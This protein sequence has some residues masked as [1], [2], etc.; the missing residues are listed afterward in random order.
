MHSKNTNIIYGI[1]AVAALLERTPGDVLELFVQDAHKN[2]RVLNLVQQARRHTI[3][4]NITRRSGLD[5]LCEDGKHQGIAAAVRKRTPLGAS[6][7]IEIVSNTQNPLLLILDGVEDPRNLGACLRS[8]AAAGV[9]A[10]VAPRG[11]SAGLTGVAQTAASGAAE[12]I[13][14]ILVGNIA[15]TLRA[16]K[17]SG[18]WL[19]GADARSRL[20]HYQGDLTGACALVL[21]GEGRGLRRLTAD[22][23]DVLVHIPMTNGME[24][25]NV[26]VAA[27]VLL[28]EAVRQR[29]C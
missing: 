21:G 10:V 27:G 13:P 7:L 28:Y 24:S 9:V 5:K 15:R 11:H 20:P 22:L 16:L 8:A 12:L 23:C 29:A 1:N 4:I 17:E 25:L 18:V 19:I 3:G 2:K 26:S 6:D 14:Y